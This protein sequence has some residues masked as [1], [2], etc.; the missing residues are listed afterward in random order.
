M[1][2]A[3]SSANNSDNTAV[4]SPST[5]EANMIPDLDDEK[6]RWAHYALAE[7]V[8]AEHEQHSFAHT[9]PIDTTV[10][11]G[12]PDRSTPR[13]QT[14]QEFEDDM[15]RRSVRMSINLAGRFK[16]ILSNGQC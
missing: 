4:V 9:T 13:A 1:S 11:K 7:A 14:R 6:V 10:P 5:P 16:L 2:G 12:G 8:D 15:R 3:S